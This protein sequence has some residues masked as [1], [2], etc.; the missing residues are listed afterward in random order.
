MNNDMPNAP[1]DPDALT[2]LQSAFG[3]DNGSPDMGN[4]D[5]SNDQISGNGQQNPTPQAQPSTSDGNQFGSPDDAGSGSDNNP[6]PGEDGYDPRNDP[7]RVEYFQ[8]RADRA[9]AELDKLKNQMETQQPILK[10]INENP[11]VASKVYSVIQETLGEDAVDTGA[12]MP[13]SSSTI[14]RDEPK[15]TMER[16]SRPEK[17]DA[18]DHYEAT[19]NPDSDSAKYQASLAEYNEKLTE[20]N[21]HVAEVEQQR[22]DYREQV[23]QQQQQQQS[24]VQQA[25]QEA[26][27]Q[28][29]LQPKEAAKFIQWAQD[30]NYKMSDLVKLWQITQNTA[31]NTDQ[32]VNQ[33]ND[34]NQ[35]LQAPAPP[36]ATGSGQAPPPQP[37]QPQTEGE[38]FAAALKA[39]IGN[40]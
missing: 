27:Y 7:N 15:L 20:Y 39:A 36:A 24:Q 4:Q 19:T 13:G 18:Y 34:R 17:P 35:R 25:Y 11:A 37:D 31:G 12:Q 38:G 33:L 28:H 2:A 32:R 21:E 1:T 30:P 29:N 26:V 14:Q 10:Y 23:V 3:G 40:R 22:R 8:S 9:T 16:P 5:F 6:A